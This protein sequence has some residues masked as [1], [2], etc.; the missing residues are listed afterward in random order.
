MKKTIV[1]MSGIA[2]LSFGCASEPEV[3]VMTDA[4][5]SEIQDTE[6]ENKVLESSKEELEALENELE[7]AALILDK[8]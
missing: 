1:L 7:E 2:M 3:E 5:I 8:L 6:E 4:E